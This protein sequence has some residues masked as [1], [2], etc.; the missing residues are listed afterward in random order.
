M[1]YE[2]NGKPTGISKVVL[3]DQVKQYILDAIERGELLPG[4]RL[5]E[6]QLARQFGI[7]QAPV[8]EAIRELVSTG[9]LIREPHK[10]ALVR[11]LTDKDMAEIYSVRAT[12]ESLAA[13][14][15][16]QNI[17]DQ[18]LQMLHDILEKLTEMGKEGDFI[19]AARYDCQFHTL[20]IEI[21][22]NRLIYRIYQSLQVAQYTLITMR[23]SQLSLEKLASRHQRILD[24]LQT[25][26]PELARKAMRQHL[27][28]L[29]PELNPIVS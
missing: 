23:R 29:Q 24:A 7:S 19:S 20:I 5:V 8:R 17:S 10:G 1:E 4:E 12:L 13:H 11:M 14:Q 16:A 15:A 22:G 27:E 18:Q 25:R 26:D 6:S 21:S 9:F 3:S 28:E 2:T